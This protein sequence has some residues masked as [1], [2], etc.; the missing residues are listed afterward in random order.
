MT[1]EFIMFFLA[2][3]GYFGLTGNALFAGMGRRHMGAMLVT[4]I[5]VLVHVFMVW[6]FRYEWQLSQA[7][8]NGYIGF[9]LFHG[10]LAMILAAAFLPM[11]HYRRAVIT[12]FLLVSMGANGATLRYGEVFMYFFPVLILSLIGWVGLAWMGVRRR[13][14]VG[15]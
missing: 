14:A 9:S 11:K 12:A 10:A 1:I 5:V 7:V 15:G 8:R 3:I 6:H 4:A 2:M 13:Q